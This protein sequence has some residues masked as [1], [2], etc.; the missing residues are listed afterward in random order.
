MKA[1]ARVLSLSVINLTEPYTIA[2][3]FGEFL[4]VLALL[5]QVTT[6]QWC[7][8]SSG[9]CDYHSQSLGIMIGGSVLGI[10]EACGQVGGLLGPSTEFAVEDHLLIWSWFGVAELGFE[11][12]SRKVQGLLKGWHCK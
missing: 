6:D 3:V 9:N 11:L 4:K 2:Y 5:R 12:V 10:S 1:M 8:Y 7:S